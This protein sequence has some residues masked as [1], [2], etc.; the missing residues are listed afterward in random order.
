MQG[1]GISDFDKNC[2]ATFRLILLLK[3]NLT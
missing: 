3:N 1:R 2:S